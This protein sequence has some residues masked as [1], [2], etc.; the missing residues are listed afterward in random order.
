MSLAARYPDTYQRIDS[1][2]QHYHRFLSLK[3]T[4]AF[5]PLFAVILD[6]TAMAS[7]QRLF[8]LLM[9][10]SMHEALVCVHVCVVY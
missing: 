2:V 7:Y 10:V 6:A 8:T 4:Y 9:K 3:L 1:I 5:Q